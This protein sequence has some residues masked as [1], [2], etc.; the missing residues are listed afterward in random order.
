MNS[1]LQQVTNQTI[2][3]GITKLKTIDT[4]KELLMQ[5]NFNQYRMFSQKKRREFISSEDCKVTLDEFPNDIGKF[6]EI[7][8]KNPEQLFHI[9][10]TLELQEENIER[11]NYGEIIKEKQ[12]NLPEFYRR[13]CVFN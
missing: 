10:K 5:N 6:L 1:I 7:E 11:R 2:P 13:T 9:T 12:K 8:T 3:V 4:I